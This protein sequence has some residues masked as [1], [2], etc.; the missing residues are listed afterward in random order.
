VGVT[1]L[2]DFDSGLAAVAQARPDALMILEDPLMSGKQY[3]RIADFT[4]INR[5]PSMSEAGERVRA[6]GLVGYGRNLPAL[7][8]RGAGYVDRILKGANPGDLPI[9]QPNKFDF[10]INLKTAQA[11]GI[12]IPPSLLGQTTELIQ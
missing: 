10:L 5:I 3:E 7:W 9:E 11:L 6:G 2:D 8:R 1:G 12:T 4:L